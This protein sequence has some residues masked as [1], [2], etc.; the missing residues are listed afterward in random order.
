[1]AGNQ[2]NKQKFLTALRLTLGTLQFAVLREDQGICRST[3]QVAVHLTYLMVETQGP[4]EIPETCQSAKGSV[5]NRRITTLRPTSSVNMTG[6]KLLRLC[7]E[8]LHSRTRMQRYT[9]L[10][11]TG[12]TTPGLKTSTRRS[13]ITGNCA[14]N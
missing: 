1:M 9:S 3:A 6:Q 4:A 5:N 13:W 14:K 11:T 12:A 8:S 7:G 10:C 2:P